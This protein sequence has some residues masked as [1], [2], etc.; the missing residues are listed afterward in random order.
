MIGIAIPYRR[1]EFHLKKFME[2]VPGTLKSRKI[3]YSI[4]IVEQKNEK[5][6]NRGKLLNIGFD[7]L[8]KNYGIKTFIS[9][10][11][12]HYPHACCPYEE[13]NEPCLLRKQNYK[14]H[15]GGVFSIGSDNFI[16]VNGYSNI[17]WGYGSEDDEFYLRLEREN[18]LPIINKN[19]QFA[20]DDHDYD[21]DP[22]NKL[23]QQN[24]ELLQKRK[25]ET[26]IDYKTD[27]LTTLK[28][29]ILNKY[30]TPVDENTIKIEV[31]I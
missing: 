2:S 7:F 6:F 16:K 20:V 24:Y 21:P 9:H 23:Y 15:V 31:D 5:P 4:V 25:T 29:T 19:Y 17:F 1:R 10:D 3:N 8:Y 22:G 26:K 12:D 14:G 30:N 28:Y 13:L 11:V 18:L 27:G